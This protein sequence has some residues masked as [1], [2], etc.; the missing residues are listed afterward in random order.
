MIRAPDREQLLGFNPHSACL[1]HRNK[2]LALL[3]GIVKRNMGVGQGALPDFWERAFAG[4]AKFRAQQRHRKTLHVQRRMPKWALPQKPNK[5]PIDK[6][7][8][9]PCRHRNEYRAPR[10][11]LNPAQVICHR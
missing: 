5:L 2:R 10:Q 7:K 9:E 8:I 3:S 11:A 6:Q 4:F 1:Q